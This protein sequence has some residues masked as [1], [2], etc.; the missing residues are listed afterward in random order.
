MPDEPPETLDSLVPPSLSRGDVAMLSR[1]E[2]RLFG[3]SRFAPQVIGHYSVV[4][5]LG[6]GGMGVVY[7]A[8]DSRLG[9]R[10][11]L[12]LLGR[13]LRSERGRARLIAEARVLAKLSHPHV[14]QVYDVGEHDGD[15]YVAMELVE[16]QNLAR[17]QS[18]RRPWRAVVDVYRQA[19]AGLVAAHRAGIVH[20]DFKPAN[21]L[22]A[23]SGI[24]KVADFG[25]AREAA[26]EVTSE[27]LEGDETSSA[28]VRV[29]GTMGYIA[30]ELWQGADPDPRSDQF[31]FCA[32][33]WEALSGG[34]P[35]ADTHEL[36]APEHQPRGPRWL[37]RVI[38]RGLHADPDKRWPS[39]DALVHELDARPRRRRLALAT[40]CTV[41]A[42]AAAWWPS[43]HHPECSASPELEVWTPAAVG[44]L[45][46]RFRVGP[47][48]GAE[49]SATAVVREL[50]D[51]QSRWTATRQDLCRDHAAGTISSLAL[52]RGRACLERARIRASVVRNA[53][54]Q[55]RSL[56]IEQAERLIDALYDPR[57]CLETSMHGPSSVGLFAGLVPERQRE[58]E[59]AQL[60][61]A[62]A[63]GEYGDV[64][65]RS[66]ALSEAEGPSSAEALLV[67]GRALA[68]QEDRVEADAS[69]RDANHRAVL[70]QAH[71]LAFEVQLALAELSAR[72]FD[73]PLAAR[74]WL[75]QAQ[76]TWTLLGEPARQWVDYRV[77]EALVL[78]AE[79]EVGRARTSLRAAVDELS[80]L[81]VSTRELGRARLH[82]ANVTAADGDQKQAMAIYQDLL[83]EREQQLSPEHPA[84]GTLAFNIGDSLAELGE[85]A[86]A[87]QM[88]DRAL[89]IQTAAY[90]V[91]SRRV[92]AVAT[93]LAEV[94]IELGDYPR[95]EALAANAWEV[96]ARDLQANDPEYG[97]PLLVLA[98]AHV[99]AESWEAA[100][101]DY[102]LILERLEL[103]ASD[104]ARV[105]HTLAWLLC[106][107]QRC[108]EAEPH[109]EL[110]LRSESPL[111]R[112]SAEI[113]AGELALARANPARAVERL[114]VVLAE[115]PRL[116]AD[117]QDPALEAEAQA[118]LGLALAAQGEGADARAHLLNARAGEEHLPSDLREQCRHALAR[119]PK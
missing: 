57:S 18:Q 42:L 48:P 49:A 8:V 112:L 114:R 80:A 92:V 60:H 103:D 10:V 6:S 96:Q 53:L 22:I 37:R 98:W 25:L 111:T 7:A 115:L 40:A 39:I 5:R 47:H 89:A 55:E 84:I 99:R 59:L 11:A 43:P 78:E 102:Q 46:A 62:L 26:Q 119:T 36:G 31:A 14:V 113:T 58:L 91:D 1:I 29:V 27:Q 21:V 33:L 104:L 86:A 81:G 70:A 94:E 83:R 30:P 9:R 35:F 45:R 65:A 28:G 19:G 16:G 23:D 69:L 73:N 17:W 71:A 72:K 90:G 116:S 38:A 107:L 32:S 101:A 95:A 44:Q 109:L 52:D 118:V 63:Q 79:G 68:A 82:L 41:A 24:V 54:L 56:D 66:D 117:H 13:K 75:S 2:R 51:Y 88:L 64:L 108:G 106:R 77:V 20:C 74:G 67:R 61:V 105:H 93:R 76:I 110:A 15:I 12:K 34:R 85:W 3:E 87:R 4:E 100:L 50:E 97:A